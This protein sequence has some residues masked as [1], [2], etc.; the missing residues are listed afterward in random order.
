MHSVPSRPFPWTS[1]S[2]LSFYPTHFFPPLAIEMGELRK[3]L[4]LQQSMSLYGNQL[5]DLYIRER[6][7]R[8][9]ETRSLHRWPDDLVAEVVSRTLWLFG[10][11]QL[12]PA[13]GF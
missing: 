13:H 9:G 7:C 6:R 2:F 5:L 10:L 12:L 4:L 8:S 11:M 3:G 1:I